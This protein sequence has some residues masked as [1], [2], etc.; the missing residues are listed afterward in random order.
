MPQVFNSLGVNLTT[1]KIQVVEKLNEGD[2]FWV[3]NIDEEHF[4]NLID[5]EDKEAKL[6]DILQTAFNELVLRK[7]P[8]AKNVAVALPAELFKVFQTP[9]E[10][11][12]SREDLYLQQKWEFR[13]LVPY[14]NPDDF[15][16]RKILVEQF[17][18][19]SYGEVC[20][21]ALKRKFL[22]TL[23]RFFARN[24]FKL[25]AVDHA[26]LALLPIFKIFFPEEKYLLSIQI[27]DMNFSAMLLQGK[28]LLVFKSFKISEVGVI[29][30]KIKL[31]LNEFAN[32]G[33]NTDEINTAYF[34]G[35]GISDSM[36]EK[37]N[38]EFG[39]H[40]V[41][42]NPFSSA[43]ISDKLQTNKLFSEKY[44]SFASAFGISLRLA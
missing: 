32:R 8:V 42:I 2:K 34:S 1:T 39:F 22:Q 40:P 11:K 27:S 12:L 9:F 33:I 7:S 29:N 16:L 43:A 4:E 14:E 30:S 5:F 21:L 25:I 23:H 36:L 6:I 13:N 20:T 38:D 18:S 35:D 41:K 37:I 3:E 15:I 26:Q 28:K 24:K 19:S 10:P 44:Y 31:L 17:P